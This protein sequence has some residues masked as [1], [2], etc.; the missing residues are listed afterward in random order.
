MAKFFEMGG[1]AIYVWPAFAVAA[2]VMIGLL[3]TSLRTLRAREAVLRQLESAE[4][5][6]DE[7]A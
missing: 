4:R 2:L 3:V 5:P 1:Y 7:R 6:G